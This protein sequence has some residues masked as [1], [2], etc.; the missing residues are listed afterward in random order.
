MPTFSP[1]YVEPGAYPKYDPAESFPVIPGGVRVL[2]LIGSGKDTKE[3]SEEAVTKGVLNSTDE[4]SEPNLVSIDRVYTVEN[5]YRAETDYLEGDNAVDWSPVIS[6]SVMTGKAGP[7]DFFEDNA[8]DYTI[9]ISVDG[10]DMQTVVF[11]AQVTP[12]V[13]TASE[14][15]TEINDQTDGILAE[16]V[17][18]IEDGETK[19]YVKISSTSE[20]DSSIL[21]GEI[22]KD[23]GDVIGLSNGIQDEGSTEPEE[24]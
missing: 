22:S 20:N 23:G 3:I 16:V 6:A 14:V 2:A 8:E 9:D 11:P 13:Y 19:N 10:G 17:E 24:D 21:I 7:Y 4:L 18:E 12:A 5:E 1:S 15:V